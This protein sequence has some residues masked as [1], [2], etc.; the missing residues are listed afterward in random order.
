MAAGR[1][2]RGRVLDACAAPGGKSGHLLE[3]GGADIDLTCVELDENRLQGV[4]DNLDRLGLDA[5]LIAGDAST[6]EELV[7]WQPVR[8]DPARCAVFGER[9]DTQAP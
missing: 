8:C 9:C 3:L 1:G 4:R 7:G 6:P 5:T 2:Q